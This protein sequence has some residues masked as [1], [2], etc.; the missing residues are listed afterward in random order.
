MDS[1]EILHSDKD[2]YVLFV[3]SPNMRQMNPRWQTTAILQKND[4]SPYFGNG[5]TDRR[6]FDMLTHNG[7][8]YPSGS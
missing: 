4:K 8:C 2:H 3:D 5:W 1:T 6:E 7:P